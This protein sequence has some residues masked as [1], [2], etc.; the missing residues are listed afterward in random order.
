M[1]E[2]VTWE[3]CPNCGRT[4]AVGWLDGN[5][6]EFDCTGGC[7]LSAAQVG[8]FMARRRPPVKWLTRS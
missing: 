3:I 5:L 4:A 6:V 1:S 2:R 7:R 8:A